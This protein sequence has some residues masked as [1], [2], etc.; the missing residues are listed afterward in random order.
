MVAAM[1]KLKRRETKQVEIDGVEYGLGLVPMADFDPLWAVVLE[2]IATVVDGAK[3]VDLTK[4]TIKLSDLDMGAV[5]AAI[6][7]TK[8]NLGW[9]FVYGE[10]GGLLAK[11]STVTRGELEERL[12]AVYDEHFDEKRAFHFM[13]WLAEA[14]RH[15]T[16]DFFDGLGSILGG[17]GTPGQSP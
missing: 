9:R 4:G 13:K 1:A 15:N 16:G 8:A 12:D 6:Q 17:P 2:V 5:A 14:V 11:H 7:K 3:G 10:L